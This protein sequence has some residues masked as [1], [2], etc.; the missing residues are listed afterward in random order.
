MKLL[1]FLGLEFSLTTFSIALCDLSPI[2]P[3]SHHLC[4]HY[5]RVTSAAQPYRFLRSD[6]FWV[7]I[8]ALLELKLSSYVRSAISGVA[9][10]IPLQ[11]VLVFG[12]GF[13][14][15]LCNLFYCLVLL[16]LSS[17]VR[18]Y[19]AKCRVASPSNPFRFLTVPTF[20]WHPFGCLVHCL[21][22]GYLRVSLGFALLTTFWALLER[23]GSFMTH[24]LLFS[25]IFCTIIFV[26]GVLLGS[27]PF[28]WCFN[29]CTRSLFA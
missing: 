13:M 12:F 3:R 7:L 8:L 11:M 5:Y 24:C 26:L 4:F 2:L 18:F 22:V 25:C 10:P 14:L 6:L 29:T 1:V 28:I 17:F 15:L 19:F 16:F 20:L 23:P 21:L 9:S 27:P